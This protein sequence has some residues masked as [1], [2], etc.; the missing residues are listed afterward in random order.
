MLKGAPQAVAVAVWNPG[1]QQ[2]VF[3]LDKAPALAADQSLEL[4]IVEAKEGA[5]PVS[6]GVF[7]V[8]ADHAARLQFKTSAPVGAIAAFAVSR[9][10]NDGVRAH[11]A[12]T[13]VIMMGKS[14]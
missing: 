2:G 13:E 7:P 1:K 8:G 3:T 5:K 4:W 9:E 11:A 6:A 12:P 14:H 10:K